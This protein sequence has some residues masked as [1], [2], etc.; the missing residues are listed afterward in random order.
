MLHRHHGDNFSN[1]SANIRDELPEALQGLPQELTI[2]LTQ[3]Y[4]LTKRP[5]R[6]GNEEIVRIYLRDLADLHSWKRLEDS[7]GN[8]CLETDGK[9]KGADAKPVILQGHMD[10][11][12]CPDDHD[13][14][15]EPI[16]LKR[17]FRRIPHDGELVEV[18]C[19][20]NTSAGLDNH[21]G[22][23]MAL[24]MAIDPSLDH[25]PLRILLTPDEEVGLTGA[26]HF[27]A[28]I[29]HADRI[30][31]FDTEL[32]NTPQIP[33]FIISCAGGRQLEATFSNLNRIEIPQGFVP[34]EVAI[35]G[36]PG[37]HSGV[38]I[39]EGRGNAIRILA[40][41]IQEANLPI[42]IESVEG[43]DAHNK[44]PA[45]AKAVIWADQNAIDST[46]RSLTDSFAFYKDLTVGVEP[47]K[48]KPSI[49]FK[50]LDVNRLAKVIDPL[51]IG[52]VL[53]AIVQV[54][55][56]P[57]SYVEKSPHLVE[58]SSNVAT[59]ETTDQ[60][61]TLCISGR[62]SKEGAVEEV[63]DHMI[64]QLVKHGAT[65]Q[66]LNQYPFWVFND[67]NPLLTLGL[68][69]YA[70]L[71]RERPDLFPENASFGGIHAGLECGLLAAKVTDYLTSTGADFKSVEAISCG[72]LLVGAHSEEEALG[73]KSYQAGWHFIKKYLEKLC[74][75]KIGTPD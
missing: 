73:V 56:G 35:K 31:N 3:L 20:E 12:F 43:G 14:E 51:V 29:A 38:L 52:N 23:A 26:Q 58:T 25:P 59:V 53:D 22:V 24:A 68:E 44:I 47:G 11:V 28:S 54:K 17:E 40:D 21:A 16:K 30:I 61:I 32:D 13:F 57:L 67:K 2:A 63:Q 46:I 66:V 72:Y 18:I 50:A 45:T 74:E 70:E 9:G 5:A 36:F 69:T 27:D 49:E 7:A 39:H 62:S 42:Y 64:V 19:A 65:C 4:E 41:V 60:E 37:G 8:L 10:I 6:S 33:Y 48:P 71:Q 55:N 75:R 34:M 1:Q 15:R